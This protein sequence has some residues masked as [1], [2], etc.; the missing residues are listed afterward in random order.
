M[1][2]STIDEQNTIEIGCLIT[3]FLYRKKSSYLLK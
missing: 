1:E 3:L 2:D